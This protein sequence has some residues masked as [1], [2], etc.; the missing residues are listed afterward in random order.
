MDKLQPRREV[1]RRHTTSDELP[2]V[3]CT[4]HSLFASGH[5]LHK[6]EQQVVRIDARAAWHAASR[7]YFP[8]RASCLSEIRLK[9][10][11]APFQHIIGDVSMLGLL[12]MLRVGRPAKSTLPACRSTSTAS[13]THRGELASMLAHPDVL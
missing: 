1:P 11:Y 5:P 9:S 12:G 2:L 8:K 3:L 10:G 7:K 4:P 6:S 13:S